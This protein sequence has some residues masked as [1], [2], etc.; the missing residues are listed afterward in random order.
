MVKNTLPLLMPVAVAIPAIVF[1]VLFTPVDSPRNYAELSADSIHYSGSSV[2]SEDADLPRF[3]LVQV[4]N[5]GD[6][7]ESDNGGSPQLAGT[8]AGRH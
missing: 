4:V 6:G 3:V 1:Y 5:S 2:Q 7:G 8:D